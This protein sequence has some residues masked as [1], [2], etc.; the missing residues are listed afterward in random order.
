MSGRDP[1]RRRIFDQEDEID[2]DEYLR[3]ADA[4]LVEISPPIDASVL[5]D[6]Q[7]ER[8]AEEL[9][10]RP[11]V[12]AQ[13]V[14]I[15]EQRNGPWSGNNQLGIQQDFAPDANN[16]QTILKL[17]EWGM[18]EVWS[19]MLGITYSDFTVNGTALGITAHVVAGVGGGVQEFD[20]DWLQGT[21]FSAN[22]NALNVIARYE[23]SS[24]IPDD[25]RLRVTLARG[26]INC[27]QPTL[28][29]QFN[30]L[31]TG[32]GVVLSPVIRIPD[33]ARS[34][35]VVDRVVP[36]ATTTVYSA[37]FSVLLK[38]EPVGAGIV[39]A[40]NGTSL[41]NFGANGYPISKFQRYLQLRADGGGGLVSVVP[42]VIFFL[43]L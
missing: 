19:L 13:K 39:G 23:A 5:F 37:D 1:N 15:V 22:M 34:F 35:M 16:E 2:Y 25:I 24:N 38:S 6:P 31:I 36:T 41:L 14:S 32:G 28:T 9:N 29:R 27:G 30:A 18:P 26:K 40:V 8:R 12:G 7:F 17:D 20:V 43:G 3:M 21:A 11:Y 33:F 10:R 4:G 42:T